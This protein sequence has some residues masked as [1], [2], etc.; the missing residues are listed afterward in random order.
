M[1]LVLEDGGST[2]P[3]VARVEVRMKKTVPEESASARIDATIGEL[4]D[5]RGEMFALVVNKRMQPL[6][7]RLHAASLQQRLE[8]RR[9]FFIL[10][11]AEPHPDET[12]ERVLLDLYAVEE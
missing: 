6:L 5:W 10:E 4:G 2:P 7:G 12:E 8:Q 1:R 9:V 11:V 3:L